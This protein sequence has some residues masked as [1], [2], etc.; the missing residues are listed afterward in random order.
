MSRR[1]KKL[2]C[3]MTAT[4]EAPPDR[5]AALVLTARP[6][7]I[8]PGNAW[9]LQDTDGVLTGGPRHFVAR[10]AG[11]AMKI[12]VDEHTFAMQGG[13]WY[14]GE[15]AVEAHP[16]GT[17]LRHRVYDVAERMRWGV[18]PANR[19]FIGFTSRQKQN[20]AALLARV[21][22]ELNATTRMEGRS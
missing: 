10:L 19:F 13:W 18:P 12:D 16:R 1:H 5:V 15:Y 6:G 11:H 20:F 8:G 22:A 21:G 3:E 17:C 2:L 14:R 9:L 4:I 7:P